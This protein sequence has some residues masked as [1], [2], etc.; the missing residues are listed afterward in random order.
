MVSNEEIRNAVLL[1]STAC[2]KYITVEEAIKLGID[3]E[4]NDFN[5]GVIRGVRFNLLSSNDVGADYIESVQTAW[6]TLG[7]K[8]GEFVPD[9]RLNK[10]YIDATLDCQRK[11]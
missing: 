2:K 10:I 4:Q 9:S 7:F 3:Y 1:V 8:D 6:I 11:K 5:S